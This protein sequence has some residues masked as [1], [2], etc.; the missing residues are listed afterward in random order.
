MAAVEHHP[1][2]LLAELA[3]G[4]EPSAIERR[5]AD[6]GAEMQRDPELLALQRTERVHFMSFFV[7]PS[8]P[9]VGPA[10]VGLEL[11]WD[12]SAQECYAALA[13]TA[14]NFLRVLFGDCV[15]FPDAPSED[16]CE[17]FLRRIDRGANAYYVGTPGRSVRQVLDEHRLLRA[18]SE[19]VDAVGW[20]GTAGETLRELQRQCRGLTSAPEP[21]PLR[22]RASPR[23]GGLGR[24]MRA[25][26]RALGWVLASVLAVLGLV[27][28]V[29]R[30]AV[31]L[32]ATPPA[33]SA[34]ANAA[35]TL[36]MAR[37]FAWA[38]VL[39]VPLM[40]AALMVVPWLRESPA[41]LAG[42]GRRLVWR[43]LWKRYRAWA[44][45]ALLV[46][47]LMGVVPRLLAPMPPLLADA[48]VLI[49]GLLLVLAVAAASL[50][51]SG[52]YWA[53]LG[54][55]CAAGA[56]VSLTHGEPSTLLFRGQV[57]TV[58]ELAVG[59]GGGTVL[60]LTQVAVL[61]AVAHVGWGRFAGPALSIV[62]LGIWFALLSL[63]LFEPL[64]LLLL[65][66]AVLALPL[67]VIVAQALRFLL[68]LRRYEERDAQGER[69]WDL[70]HL[71]EVQAHEDHVY[72]NHLVNVSTIKGEPDSDEYR[73]RL[74]T[75]EGV[76]RAVSLAARFVFNRG[77][78]GGIKS[79]HFARFLI[80]P[81]R[82][83]LLFLSN[84]DD[85]FS[86]YLGDFTDV[87]GVT[88]VWGNTVG[89][90]R[91]L[92]LLYEGITDEQRFKAFGRRIQRR[93]LGWFSAYPDLSV[94]NV[95]DASA[96]RAA[97]FRDVSEQPV[98]AQRRPIWSH[99]PMTEAE[100]DAILRRL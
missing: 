22:V 23:R 60:A 88:A 78:L 4:A 7:V 25:G 33:D 76:L 42:A 92:F 44:R 69:E 95:D 28:L 24:R 38:A 74:A 47:G 79:I 63:H 52:P 32:G 17:R 39:C 13:Q 94:Q 86:S 1:I 59:A 65:W 89:F 11:N 16:A 5:L 41:R 71:D 58:M 26:V 2:S 70:E 100:C 61:G 50:A 45:Y 43:A 62:L 68:R 80:L 36:L 85:A 49:L 9:G 29:A 37:P 96:V 14:P 77:D 19:R 15:G 98:G 18:A 54:A 51:V 27:D 90:P 91:P 56:W 73:F 55:L 40:G 8:E 83:R 81:D 67:V 21:P 10:Y 12:G 64:R 31:A 30:T 46:A 6:L 99:G 97:L 20:C 34:G 57:E 84:Y 72:Q 66:H 75:L 82:R 35:A 93:T 48:L 53:A 3:A 87:V